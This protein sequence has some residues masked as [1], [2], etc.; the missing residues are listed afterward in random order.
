MSNFHPSIIHLA[1]DEFINITLILH[2]LLQGLHM[3]GGWSS[4]LRFLGCGRRL[5]QTLTTVEDR[6]VTG[7]A[8]LK[9]LVQSRSLEVCCNLLGQLVSPGVLLIIGALAH[10]AHD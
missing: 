1:S 2:S 9:T 4:V 7:Q 6:D 10:G 3:P 8:A 5:Q